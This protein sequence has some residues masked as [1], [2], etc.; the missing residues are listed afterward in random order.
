MGAILQGLGTAMRRQADVTRAPPN[1]AHQQAQAAAAAMAVI[2]FERRQ[3]F[4]EAKHQKIT[5]RFRI[6]AGSA[7]FFIAK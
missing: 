2:L 7:F 4:G 1:R 5:P 6:I 3:F